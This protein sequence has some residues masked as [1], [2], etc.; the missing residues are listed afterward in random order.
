MEFLISSFGLG[1]PVSLT[2][3]GLLVL[4]VPSP[5]ATGRRDVRGSLWTMSKYR[6]RPSGKVHQT[7]DSNSSSYFGK[8]SS[9]GF[10]VE[11]ISTLLGPYTVV[12]KK[13]DVG[14]QC[15]RVGR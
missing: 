8:K 14:V 6:H 10:T 11:E 4:C 7:G 13:L 5:G 15:L 1:R 2:T 9:S 12:E 3:F